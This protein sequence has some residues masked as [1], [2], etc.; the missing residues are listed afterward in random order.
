[1]L[2]AEISY[3]TNSLPITSIIR[4][5]RPGRLVKKDRVVG[6]IYYIN[7][8]ADERFLFRILFITVSSLIFYKFLHIVNGVIYGIFKEACLARK[9][10]KNNN[11]QI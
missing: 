5:R 6:R 11:E 2:T 4:R 9:L 8:G 3:V 10:I 1:M 7:P